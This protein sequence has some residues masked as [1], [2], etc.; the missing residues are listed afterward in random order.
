MYIFDFRK[1]SVILIMYQ[2]RLFDNGTLLPRDYQDSTVVLNLFLW[3]T[4]LRN[5]E[6]MPILLIQ[7]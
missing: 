6:C 1:G 2:T 7:K 4:D 3:N 5:T